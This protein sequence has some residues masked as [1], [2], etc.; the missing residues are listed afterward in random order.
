M[1]H[2]SGLSS[3]GCGGILYSL[4]VEGLGQNAVNYA[5]DV[6][7]TLLILAIVGSNAVDC[8]YG[9]LV[10]GIIYMYIRAYMWCSSEVWLLLTQTYT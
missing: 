4:T 2:I 9:I 10:E 8:Y 7:I 6:V 1:L 5:S 3:V